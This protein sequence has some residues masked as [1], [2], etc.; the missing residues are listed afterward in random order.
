MLPRLPKT[1]QTVF[2]QFDVQ[3]QALPRLPLPLQQLWH[4]GVAPVNQEN[5]TMAFW[6]GGAAASAFVEDLCS[7]RRQFCWRQRCSR[8]LGCSDFRVLRQALS[9]LRALIQTRGHS[10]SDGC[11]C[12]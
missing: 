10:Y 1:A 3:L 6:L 8:R 7:S 11:F 5:Q 2:A 4:G 12:Y 9:P